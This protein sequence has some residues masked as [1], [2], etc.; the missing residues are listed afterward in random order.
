VPD[1]LVEWM[2]GWLSVGWRVKQGSLVREMPIPRTVFLQAP[3]H[4]RKW[5]A[6]ARFQRIAASKRFHDQW[7][8]ACG[9]A[10]KQLFRFFLQFPESVWQVPWEF[11]I[12]D[13]DL[14]QRPNVS[15]VRGLC[16]GSATLKSRFDQPMSV[17]ILQGD[18]GSRTGRAR[19]DLKHEAELLLQVYGSLPT[20]HRQAMLEPQIC[21][22]SLAEL[23]EVLRRSPDVLFLSGH[24]SSEPPAFILVDGSRLTPDAIAQHIAEARAELA[25]AAFWACD[26]ARAP[27]GG[28]EAPGPPF[29]LA[30]ARSGV[31]SVLAMQAPV[32][33]PGAILLAREVFEALAAGDALDVAA[34]RGRAVLLQSGAADDL[35]WA[36]PVIWSSGLPAAKLHWNCPSS[37][38]AQLQT[39]SRRL[40]MMREGRALPPPTIEELA[41]AR[42]CAGEQLC[43][44]KCT[45]LTAHKERWIRLLVAMQVVL[46]RYVIAVELSSGLE[47]AE[48]LMAWA[49]EVQQ[50]LDVRDAPS[51]EFRNILEQMRT[52]PQ[53]A[54]RRLCALPEVIV[55]LWQ[56]PD[57]RSESWFWD[58]VLGSSRVIS[59]GE[60]VTAQMLT[61]GWSVEEL[62]MRVDE[63]RLNTAYLEAPLVS[64]A[65]ALLEMAVPR[66]S[67]TALGISLQVLSNLNALIINTAAEEVILAAAAARFFRA[68]MTPEAKTAAHKA[69]MQI[70]AHISFTGRLTS[71]VREQRLVHCL[72]AGETAAAVAEACALL[73]SYRQSD[74]PRA[75]LSVMRRIGALWRS[76]PESI[77]ITT[78]W[79]HTMLGD[80]IQALFWLERS[81]ADSPLELAWQHGLRAE[82][83]KAL[84]HKEDALDEVD[85]AIAVLRDVPP[86]QATS[87]IA[88]RLRAYRQDRARI[89]QYLFYEADKAAR[90]YEELLQEWQQ[91]AEAAIDVAVVLR[92]YAECVRTGHAP[93]TTAWQRAKEMLIHAKDLLKDNRDIPIYAE[94]EYERARVAMAEQQPNAGDLLEAARQAAAASGHL[95]LVAICEARRFWRFDSFD[96]ARWAEAEASLSAFPHHGWA[97]RTLVDGRLRAARRVTDV[98]LACRFLLANLEDLDRNPAFDA[99]SDRLRIAASVAGYAV[100]ALGADGDQKW[101]AF[102]ARP[103]ALGWLET[104]GFHT[105]QDVW[106]RAS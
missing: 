45:D 77:L 65:L 102:L 103:W 52:R 57:Y 4:L 22:P 9:G 2:P 16:E 101:S 82:I 32:S 50:G 75:V 37:K 31:A 99:G 95:M 104:N 73:A 63:D 19:L 23:P 25:F 58:P 13:L 92:N 15:L 7:L 90:E 105:P 41:D 17:L 61:D 53:V 54:W 100:L 85:A 3:S 5:R 48:G 96:P 47:T 20:A 42:R 46:P 71:A 67:V 98:G 74:R 14:A 38:L 69:C 94:L 39:A 1:H 28:R 44:I 26:T 34:A 87:L 18:D 49:E 6:H 70:F 60:R 76:L 11:L 56:P 80:T 84:G 83:Q 88:R 33:D 64:D 91:D 72:A 30:L 12:A 27:K 8:Y 62:E 51:I 55:A 79:A 89:L 21:Q 86:S 78:A 59:M 97:V 66:Q 24:G 81:I 68:R 106:G 36:C 93:G 43:W 10:D 40:R 29:Y 35:D